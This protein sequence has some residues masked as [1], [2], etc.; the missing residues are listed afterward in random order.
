M[1]TYQGEVTKYYSN[2]QTKDRLIKT[3]ES[4]NYNSQYEVDED[5]LKEIIKDLNN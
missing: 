1:I 3:I 4:R 5:Y 2:Q